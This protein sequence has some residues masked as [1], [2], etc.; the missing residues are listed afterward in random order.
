MVEEKG[1]GKLDLFSFSRIQ[2][3]N[4]KNSPEVLFHKGRKNYTCYNRK[5]EGLDE[6]QNAEKNW[7]LL[8][9]IFHKTKGETHVIKINKKD[10]GKIY[11]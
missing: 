1:S 8:L 3:I 11:A 9:I 6:G 4:L 5:R 7:E 10:L 2:N